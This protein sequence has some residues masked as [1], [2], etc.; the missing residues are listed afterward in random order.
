MASIP[1]VNKIDERN[2]IIVAAVLL[3]GTFLVLWLFT[4]E[5][6][7]PPPRDIPVMTEVPLDE[8]VLK[9]LKVEGGSGG[10]TPV[11]APVQ[12]PAP[13]TEQVITSNTKPKPTKV[14][15]GQSTHTTANNNT[16]KPSTTQQAPN[17]FGTGGS[18]TTGSGSGSGTFGNDSGTGTGGTA[19]G[20][21]GK[22]RVRLNEVSVSGI[23][24]NVDAFIHLKLTID[25]QGNVV[26]VQNI[27][28]QTTTSDQILI[29]RIMSAVKAQVKYNKDPGAALA[30]VFYTVRVKPQ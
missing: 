8:I 21:S 10:G 27:K 18:G 26:H 7:D 11:D 15:T 20:G 25:A 19:G 22:G 30:K 23:Q 3:A 5:I 13:Q 28:S 12:E 29:N 24:I 17:P 1:I 14:P 6:P 4:Y 16:N 2:G 9:E